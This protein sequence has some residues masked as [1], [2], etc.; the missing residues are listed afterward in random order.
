MVR[1][2]Y[3]PSLPRDKKFQDNTLL[4]RVEVKAGRVF[5][6]FIFKF[7]SSQAYLVLDTWVNSVPISFPHLA[8]L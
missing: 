4:F 1:A 5:L 3:V 7:F 6:D 8:K 2:K